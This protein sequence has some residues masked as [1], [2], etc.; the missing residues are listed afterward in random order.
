MKVITEFAGQNW[1][2]T[3]A[4][5]AVNEQKPAS[6]KDQ[7][8]ML[9]LTGVAVVN[10]TAGFNGDW[11]RETLQ[12]LPDM[13]GPLQFAI[14]RFSVPVP[15]N[16][17]YIVNGLSKITPFFQLEEWAPFASLGSI[18]DKNQSVDAGF[19]VDF[20]K[21]SPFLTL[22]ASGL[23]D[24]KQIFQGIKV[25]VAVRDIDA[26][27]F[28]VNYHISLLGKIAFAKPF[29]DPCQTQ[30]TELNTAQTKLDNARSNDVPH[31]LSNGKPDLE[32]NR[33]AHQAV[34]SAESDLVKKQQALADCRNRPHTD[35]P[36]TIPGGG[37]ANQ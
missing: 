16:P 24:I 20:W 15:S 29:V 17:G 1:L 28:R 14:N 12:I 34:E 4:A 8:W 10:L 26:T 23:P 11:L 2:I 22:S 35:I 13:N 27:L 37:T 31:F 5:L 7:K 3:P 19:A 33:L 21:P 36:H 6:I 18:F 25:D 9:T 30:A 32:A